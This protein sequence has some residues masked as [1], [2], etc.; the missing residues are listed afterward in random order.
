LAVYFGAVG[1]RYTRHAIPC[2][3]FA[4]LCGVLAAIAVCYW[5]FG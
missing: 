5:F 1:V 4:D 3:L 2:A